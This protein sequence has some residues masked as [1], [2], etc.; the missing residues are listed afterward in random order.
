MKLRGLD[1]DD[2]IVLVMLAD[3]ISVTDIGK[4]LHLTQPAISQRLVKIRN[5]TGVC[6]A[7]KSGRNMRMTSNGL[8][9]AVGAKEALLTL[10]R[11]LP[12]PFTHI[13]SDALVHYLFSKRGDWA[14]YESHDA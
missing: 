12:D 11:S 14:A 3:G 10:L 13:G 4:R 7:Y 9:L 8:V 1:I 6:I 5:M 2:L